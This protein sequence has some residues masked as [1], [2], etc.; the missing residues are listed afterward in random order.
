[1]GKIYWDISIPANSTGLV[2]LPKKAN[3]HLDSHT[4]DKAKYLPE[5][6][7]KDEILYR[8]PSGKYHILVERK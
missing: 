7:K 8:F 1:L 5:I 3:I 6:I 4:F 2:S